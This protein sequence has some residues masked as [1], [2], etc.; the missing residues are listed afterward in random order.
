MNKSPNLSTFDAEMKCEQVLSDA[1]NVMVSISG[2]AD[3]DVMLDLI[4][5]KQ[6]EKQFPIEIYYVFF[7]TG[8]EMQATLDHLDYLEKKYNIKIERAMANVPVPFGC[9]RYGQPFLSKYVSSMIS[10]L[11]SKNFDFAK[12][13]NKSYEELSEK[14]K[15]CQNALKWWCD[16]HPQKAEYKSMFNIN[17][18]KW[19]K[20]Y[21][22]ANPPDFKISNLCC[23]GAKKNTAHKWEEEHN[24]DTKCVGLRKAEGGI[25][26]VAVKTCF[27]NRGGAEGLSS[28]ILV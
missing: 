9:L 14:Y 10:K 12:D 7:N 15:K 16:K 25:R 17:N 13:G 20:E 19:L 23:N 5:R 1:V 27:T 22:I 3:S 11:Q 26:R 24:C 6:K 18:T 28:N 4:H 8:I 2:G 21:M